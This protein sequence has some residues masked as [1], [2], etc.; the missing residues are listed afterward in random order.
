MAN[1]GL[2]EPPEPRVTWWARRKE[3]ALSTWAYLRWYFTGPPFVEI[4]T[5]KDNRNRRRR[6]RVAS[7]TVYSTFDIEGVPKVNDPHPAD[8]FWRVESMTANCVSE[9]LFEVR[10]DYRDLRHDNKTNIHAGNG[11]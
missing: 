2:T 4:T 6:F 10:V 8:E 9:G 5:D 11:G 3:Q 7:E 1:V